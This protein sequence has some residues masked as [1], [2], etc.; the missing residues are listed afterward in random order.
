LKRTIQV[1]I[2]SG[3]HQFI[4][5]CLDLPVITQAP[6]LDELALNIREA[7]SLH[8]EGLTMGLRSAATDQSRDR[9]ATAGSGPPHTLT[10][11][12]QNLA[13]FGFASDPAIIAT[14]A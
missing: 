11:N 14:V 13:E 7:I 12:G 10:F 6:T 2:S 1:W 3:E 4:A 8:P 5:E 9:A